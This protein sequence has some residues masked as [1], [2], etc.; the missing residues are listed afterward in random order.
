[1]PSHRP[2]VRRARHARAD[3]WTGG[4]VRADR[5]VQRRCRRLPVVSSWRSAMDARR[6][7]VGGTL[8][9]SGSRSD[10]CGWP[11]CGAPNRPARSG[12]SPSSTT[13]SRRGRSCW[14]AR[15]DDEPS[16]A[17]A[18]PAASQDRPLPSGVKGGIATR[19]SPSPSSTGTP[20]HRDVL[21]FWCSGARRLR[22]SGVSVLR[23]R[24]TDA[25]RC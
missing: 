11:D 20:E 25:P 3:R 12:Y 4:P 5:R 24:S 19:R 23:V 10:W 18:R 8:R 7:V 2:V 21:V 6:R 14:Y 17:T 15:I 9:C 22:R 13:W 16:I 1:M